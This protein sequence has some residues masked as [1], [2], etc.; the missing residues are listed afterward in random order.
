MPKLKKEKGSTRVRKSELIRNISTIFIENSENAY[1]FK[2]IS[3][4]LNIKSDSQRVFINQ[5]LYQ[6]VDE[7]FLTE[8]SKGKFRLNSRGSYITG[9]IDRHGAKTYLIPEDGGETIFISEQKINTAMRNDKVKA[10]LYARRKGQEPEGE[11]VEI[12]Q[13]AQDTFVGELDVSDNYAFLV[14]SNRI[15]NNDIFIYL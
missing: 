6:L 15:I 14:V 13:R 3:T 5:L 1:N 4:L 9:T 10:H 2:Q 7:D 8:I 12:I 11:V